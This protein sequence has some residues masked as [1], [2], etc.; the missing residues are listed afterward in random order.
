M[1]NY[2]LGVIIQPLINNLLM[3]NLRLHLSCCTVLSVILILSYLYLTSPPH[4]QSNLQYLYIPNHYPNNIINNK[5]NK[6]IIINYGDGCCKNAQESNCKTAVEV[7]GADYCYKYN[8]GCIDI[9]VQRSVCTGHMFMIYVYLN[10]YVVYMQRLLLHTIP[11][12]YTKFQKLNLHA[13]LQIYYRMKGA[14]GIIDTA[15]ALIHSKMHTNMHQHTYM[16]AH[17]HVRSET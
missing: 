1:S 4:T 13:S 7:G 9:F 16:R 2:Y 5:N 3:R 11:D 10:E 17:T 12:D 15:H 8:A 14:R 6:A